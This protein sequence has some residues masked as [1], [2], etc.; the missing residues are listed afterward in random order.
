MTEDQLEQEVLGWLAGV[1]WQHRYGP[2][3]AADGSAPVMSGRPVWCGPVTENCL[4]REPLF[5]RR[6][7]PVDQSDE[8]AAGFAVALVPHRHAGHRQ[9]GELTVRRQFRLGLP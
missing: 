9:A 1:G 5:S 4:D 3:L 8:V 6:V 2:D 7:G